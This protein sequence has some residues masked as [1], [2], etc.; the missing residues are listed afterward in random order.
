MVSFCSPITCTRSG[1]CR[2]G[3]RI[4]RREGRASRSDSPTNGSPPADRKARSP[5]RAAETVAGAS[6]SGGSGSTSSVMNGPTDTD[7]SDTWITSITTRSSTA[8]SNARTRGGGRHFTGWSGRGRMTPCG[9]AGATG[10]PC[11]CRIS[12]GWTPGA[13]SWSLANDTFRPVKNGPQEYLRTLRYFGVRQVR[14][15]RRAGG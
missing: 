8:W 13:L 3:T 6:G 11:R 5:T 15:G 9:A 4:F 10:G 14:R 2:R 7:A 1:R 12:M